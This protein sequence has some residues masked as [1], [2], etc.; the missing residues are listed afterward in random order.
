M[1]ME[2]K[3]LEVELQISY[4]K[5]SEE[6]INN[7]SRWTILGITVFGPWFSVANGYLQASEHCVT[8]DVATD[9]NSF[10]ERHLFREAPC[11]PFLA[12]NTVSL[13]S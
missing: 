4:I 6:W 8:V 10:W 2:R 1:H 9:V 12:Q 7:I 3:N 5:E 11:K 13:T